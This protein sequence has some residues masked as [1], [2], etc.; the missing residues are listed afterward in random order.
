MRSGIAGLTALA[1]TIAVPAE[2][3]DYPSR[4]IT[5]VVPFAP[6][7]TS[8][9]TARLLTPGMSQALGQP[10]VIENMGGAGGTVGTASVARARPDGY[11]LLIH[12]VGLASA[13]TL[14][15]NLPYDTLRDLQPIGLLTDSAMVMTGYG[16]L[17]P[18][19]FAG[20]VG[21]LRENR[22]KA[23]IANAG[24]GSASH[25]CGMLFMQAVGLQLLTVPY[26]TGG[27]A[28]TATLSNEANL[29]CD[30]VTSAV[31]NLA[32]RA[33]RAYVVTMPQ[34]DPA[35]PEVPA[36]PEVGLPDFSLSIWH[37]LYAPRG[38]PQPIVDRLAGVMRDVLADPVVRSRLAE[39]GTQIVAPERTTPEMLRA[40]LAAEIAR[41]APLIRAA[42]AY[43][44]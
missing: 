18:R 23:S 5:L 35:L 19:D 34:R 2:A 26:R 28:V 6:G 32:A 40:H 11:R 30:S 7:G 17:P 33:T 41:F 22:D 9:I 37:G 14:Y 42:G 39:L 1:L 16:G 43:A 13:A 20:L 31:P 29:F 44:D 4:P 24:I 10:V 25:L 15:R 36:T 8:D 38:T 21:W 3:Q 12:H 27:Q